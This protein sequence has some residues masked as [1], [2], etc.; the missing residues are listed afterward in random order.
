MSAFFKTLGS[1]SRTF[2]TTMN[3]EVQK[4]LFYSKARKYPSAL[5]FALDAANIPTSVYTRLIDG[6]NKNLP[7]FHRYLR[8]RKRMMGVDQL[9]YYDLYAPLVGSVNLRVH[10]GRGAAARAGRRRAARRGLSGRHQTR[11][12]QPLDRSVPERGQGVRRLLER[13]RLRRAPVHA[14]QLQRQVHRRQHAGPRAGPHDAELL[15]EQDAALSAG[16]LPDLRRRGRVHVQRDAAHRLHARDNIKDDDT[17]LSL[18][19]NYLENIKGT[20][21]R[22]T[23]FAEFE[24]RMHEMAQKG[25]PITGDALAK[26]YMD[27]TK[28]YYGHD[29]GVC[30][31]DDYIAN[32]WSY[33]PH[34]YR[35]FYVFQ[36]AT[37]FTAS[38]ALAE[39]VKNGDA[40]A[41]AKRYLAFLSA[42]GSKVSDR[43]AQ[44]RRR[45]HD[46]RRAAR[47]DDEG[48]DPRDGRNGSAARQ[49]RASGPPL[50][51]LPSGFW[52][53]GVKQNSK[54]RWRSVSTSPGTFG[55]DVIGDGDVRCSDVEGSGVQP[56][57]PG[58]QRQPRRG[59]RGGN[60]QRS[61]HRDL[62]FDVAVCRS[63]TKGSRVDRIRP[64][65]ARLRRDTASMSARAATSRVFTRRPAAARF[66]T[67]S[68]SMTTTRRPKTP[69]CGWIRASAPCTRKLR[70][71]TVLGSRLLQ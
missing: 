49:T 15:L 59:A 1:F 64:L 54:Q 51:F 32:E 13:R 11:V 26:L 67:S 5:A 16:E 58:Y 27:I 30:I 38:A 8:L 44:G 18:L 60:R 45:R 36:Y 19:G 61:R 17:R 12:R 14:D 40:E 25:Q 24:L 70:T 33:I 34:F 10:A 43:S 56:P 41:Q 63:Q 46:D 50:L 57:G 35:D 47:S 9:H 7:A 55:G 62:R 42:G 53:G 66:T 20:V 39:K 71:F 48:D 29:Q 68:G 31:V 28:K 4:V 69:T 23:Q 52:V 21:F 3:G 2:G 37:S 65:R 22:Q 6:V